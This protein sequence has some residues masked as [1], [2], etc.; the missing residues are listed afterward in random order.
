MENIQSYDESNDDECFN[1]APADPK[2]VFTDTVGRITNALN[3]HDFV[4]PQL[5]SAVA[6]FD[7]KLASLIEESAKADRKMLEYLQSKAEA[8]NV[9]SFLDRIFAL[10]G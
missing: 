8:G 9:P 6:P 1:E 3:Q 7:R 2:V 5:I 10:L 4:Y